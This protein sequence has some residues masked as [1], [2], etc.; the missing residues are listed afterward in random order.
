MAAQPKFDL[1]SL[2]KISYEYGPLK[3]V[4][5]Y[6]LKRERE[7]AEQMGKMDA[8]LKLHNKEIE[9]YSPGLIIL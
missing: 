4:L 2:L 5:E 6:L 1:D 9:Q 8:D 3:S 7:T